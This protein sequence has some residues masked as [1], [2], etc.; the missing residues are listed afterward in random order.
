MITAMSL[1]SRRPASRRYIRKQPL[2]QSEAGAVDFRYGI[3]HSAATVSPTAKS[4]VWV[5]EQW[6]AGS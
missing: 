1:L 5:M 3:T 2:L 4:G 6:Y